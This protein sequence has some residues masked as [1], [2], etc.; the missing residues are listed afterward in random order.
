[1]TRILRQRVC[2]ILVTAILFIP[3]Q[4]VMASVDNL[5]TKHCLM[6]DCD[7][8]KSS[9]QNNH[10]NH[11]ITQHSQCQDELSCEVAC[12]DCGQCH[13]MVIS[14]I[15]TLTPIHF[16]EQKRFYLS[17]SKSY[18]GSIDTPPPADLI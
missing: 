11:D 1:M 14:T 3:L 12:Q 9:L 13:L 17:A 8:T 18:I 7:H 16:N 2:F 6:P 4:S 15:T 5:S 10:D